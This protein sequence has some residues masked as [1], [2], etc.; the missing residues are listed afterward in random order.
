MKFIIH[1]IV[2]FYVASI[3]NSEEEAEIAI[4]ECVIK[5]DSID[6]DK[7]L[8]ECPSTASCE[9][10]QLVK[11]SAGCCCDNE[12]YENDDRYLDMSRPRRRGSKQLRRCEYNEEYEVTGNYHTHCNGLSVCEKDYALVHNNE[13]RKG[14]TSYER[15]NKCCCA[16]YDIAELFVFP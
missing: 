14:R 15:T 3:V 8:T 11:T 16:P 13:I 10:G 1:S 2:L 5:K 4:P 6:Q 7:M 12:Y 9:N